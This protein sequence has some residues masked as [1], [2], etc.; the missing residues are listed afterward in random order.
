MNEPTSLTRNQL[1]S[2]NKKNR[3]T[4]LKRTASLYCKFKARSK[5]EIMVG[6][7]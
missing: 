7:P 6:R 5:E 4:I 2:K 3:I 1:K